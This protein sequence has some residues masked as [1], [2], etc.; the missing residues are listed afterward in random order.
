[1]YPHATYS[2]CCTPQVENLPHC[3]WAFALGIGARGLQ[4]GIF[5]LAK[6]KVQASSKPFHSV[7]SYPCLKKPSWAGA[8]VCG[9][10]QEA[11]LKPK[12]KKNPQQKIVFLNDYIQLRPLPWL[13]PSFRTT[14]NT[15]PNVV[16]TQ[17]QRQQ[18]QRQWRAVPPY[19]RHGKPRPAWVGRQHLCFLLA[20]TLR[21]DLCSTMLTHKFPRHKVA[22]TETN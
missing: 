20:H 17:L 8:A 19:Q 5:F 22:L 1:M 3:A 2:H 11:I 14:N 16:P 12:K 9:F 4:L 15:V 6:V 18:Q 13:R 7:H 21:A 10:K